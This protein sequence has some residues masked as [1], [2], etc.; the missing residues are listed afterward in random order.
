MPNSIIIIT[1]CIGFN[2]S[3]RSGSLF[4]IFL[5]KKIGPD[6]RLVQKKHNINVEVVPESNLI[7]N[8]FSSQG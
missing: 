7:V 6:L 8:V 2:S 5:N 3:L 1:Y 4:F